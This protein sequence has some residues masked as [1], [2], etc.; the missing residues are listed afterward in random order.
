MPL[1]ASRRSLVAIAVIAVL[2]ITFV[3]GSGESH[4]INYA[5][6]YLGAKV[7]DHHN[8]AKGAHHLLVEG[9]E[10]YMT[11]PCQSERK[12]FTI[13]LAREIEISMIQL[14]NEEYFS[15]SIKNFTLIG[16]RQYPCRPPE[17]MWRVLGSLQAAHTREAQLF[18]IAKHPPVR[19]VRLLWV[20]QWGREKTCSMSTFQVYGVDVLDN[21]ASE[22]AYSGS[23]VDEEEDEKEPENEE[24]EQ[25]IQVVPAETAST[26]V[27]ANQTSASSA[28]LNRT[29]NGTAVG[30][31]H[32]N[33][34][35]TNS[36]VHGTP[37][38]TEKKKKEKP[39]PPPI[40]NTSST[41]CI[42]HDREAEEYYIFGKGAQCPVPTGSNAVVPKISSGK[43][44]ASAMLA[45]PQQQK[46]IK[47][48][49]QNISKLQ[50]AVVSLTEKLL[51]QKVEIDKLRKQNL[52]TENRLKID[53]SNLDRRCRAVS[54]SVANVQSQAALRDGELERKISQTN[55]MFIAAMVVSNLILLFII[56]CLIYIPAGS[57]NRHHHISSS[58]AHVMA[59]GTPTAIPPPPN[60]TN[61][62]DH[63]EGSAAGGVANDSLG[64]PSN[65]TNCPHSES[66][67]LDSG[68]PDVSDVEEL[69]YA[70]EEA[71]PAQRTQLLDMAVSRARIG[72]SDSP[73]SSSGASNAT[74]P[75]ALGSGQG[76]S[77]TML[78]STDELV[79]ASE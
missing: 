49:S 73:T 74:K 48:L 20:S 66:E 46:L 5:S 52:D 1:C 2:A 13:Q 68:T 67:R 14:S 26:G 63:S 15:S 32:G 23:P 72:G 70:A 9:S 43:I 19:Y 35:G 55:T 47:A 16:S 58:A 77:V 18:T 25:L 78:A 45:L 51:Q 39:K 69:P 59:F 30:D 11:I 8:D 42:D 41:Y 27:D 56:V 75:R 21:L 7:V 54:T 71:S 31:C 64:H 34:N 22:L 37:V 79:D 10:K 36:T 4:A 50:T 38:V 57:G 28:A 61:V 24:E 40:R 3:V 44:S 33:G 29:V 12:R 60:S 62:V 65:A 76:M 53:L 6:A 17:C